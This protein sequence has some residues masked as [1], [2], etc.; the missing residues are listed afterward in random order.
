M[1]ELLDDILS[2]NSALLYSLELLWV[3]VFFFFPDVTYL[4]S[5]FIVYFLSPPHPTSAPESKPHRSKG[6]VRFCSLMYPKHLELIVYD[7]QPVFNKY[8]WNNE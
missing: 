1:N 5:T 6:I 4:N 2:C 7:T 3:W 8:L